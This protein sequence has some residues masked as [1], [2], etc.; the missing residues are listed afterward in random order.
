M[1]LD[2]IHDR[3]PALPPGATFRPV[4]VE[5]VTL[6]HP[7]CIG[8]RHVGYASD[9]GGVLTPEAIEASGAPCEVK[10]CR[11]AYRDHESML[12]LFVEVE[13]DRRDLNTHAGLGPWLQSVK[14]AELGLE[15]FAFPPRA[16][17]PACA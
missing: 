13:D 10:G 17:G 12:T 2:D 7:Y 3:L 4:K 5:T 14:D 1:Q 15:G 11:L 16:G 8:P 9:H 6:P